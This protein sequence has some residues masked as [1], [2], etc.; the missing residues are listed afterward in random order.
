M[1]IYYY[2]A[3]LFAIISIF[4]MTQLSRMHGGGKPHLPWGLDAWLLPLPYLA[5]WSVLGPWVVLGYLGAVLGLRLGHGRGFDYH[6]P[7]KESGKPEKV[8][9][10][11][12]KG[13]PVYWQKFLLMFYTGLAVTL[14]LASTMAIQGAYLPALILALS[15]ALK[16]VAYLA[17]KTEI[18]EYLRGVFL[19]LGFC[20]AFI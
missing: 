18:A 12:P 11:I 2:M 17:P 20:I 14:I 5:F 19:G 13:L 16:S 3:A 9:W 1:V 6:K 10:I 8:E 7:F 15:G 4:W